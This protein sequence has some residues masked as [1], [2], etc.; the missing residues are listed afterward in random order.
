MFEEEYD[1]VR[2]TNIMELCYVNSVGERLGKSPIPSCMIGNLPRPCYLYLN[3]DSV[4]FNDK[5]DR[6]G[7]KFTFEAF[8]EWLQES[9]SNPVEELKS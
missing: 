7:R 1:S 2:C 6:I 8:L 3:G 9:H 5:G 4:G